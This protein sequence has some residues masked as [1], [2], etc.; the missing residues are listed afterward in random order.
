MYSGALYFIWIPSIVFI[1]CLLSCLCFSWG[2]APS[3]FYSFDKQISSGTEPQRR[4]IDKV[5]EDMKWEGVCEEEATKCRLRWF[6]RWF[7]VAPLEGNRQMKGIQTVS[8]CHR[9]VKWANNPCVTLKK[10][11]WK[12]CNEL[13]CVIIY[14]SKHFEPELNNERVSHWNWE[15]APSHSPLLW[16]TKLASFSGCAETRLTFHWQKGAEQPV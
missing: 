12:Q 11:L 15:K 6:A 2:I 3:L 13:A 10:L 5:E 4:F 1:I 7:A 16:W 9:I 8:G 14:S